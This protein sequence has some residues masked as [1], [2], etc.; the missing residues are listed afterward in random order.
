MLA[1]IIVAAVLL[2]LAALMLLPVGL[3]AEYSGAG[4]KVELKAAFLHFSL[5]PPRPGLKRAKK[6]RQKGGDESGQ[7]EAKQET[8]RDKKLGDLDQLLELAGPILQ[9]LGRLRRKLRVE[10]LRLEYAIGG[11]DDP[12]GAAIQY[13]VISAGGGVLMPLLDTAFDIRQWDVQLGVDFQQRRSRVAAAARGSWRL[14]SLVW[15]FLGLVWSMLKDNIRTNQENTDT[16]RS[17]SK[18]DV[19]NGRK[20]SDR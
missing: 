20:A 4:L 11:A 9:A 7:T 18:E 15:I 3:A 16:K 17:D 8:K 14:G 19:P 5:Y 10:L 6:R 1:L 12:A 13:G 2:C